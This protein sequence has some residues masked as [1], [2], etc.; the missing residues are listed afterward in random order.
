MS[1]V[2]ITDENDRVV[3]A[4]TTILQV[5]DR[6]PRVVIESDH[7]VRVVSVGIQGP[8]GPSTP[9]PGLV[10]DVM[11][12]GGPLLAVDPGSF[13]YSLDQQSLTVRRITGTTL[14][15]GNF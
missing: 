15:G 8:A 1:N 14:D 12:N 5:V 9:I 6:R 2:A 13:S 4:G 11:F 10:G 7:Q 3:L